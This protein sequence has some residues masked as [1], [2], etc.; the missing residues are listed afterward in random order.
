MILS[1][2]QARNCKLLRRVLIKQIIMNKNKIAMIIKLLI[3]ILGSAAVYY[4]YVKRKSIM[5]PN[6]PSKSDE[7]RETT[8]EQFESQWNYNGSLRE[9]LLEAAA[10]LWESYV[11]LEDAKKV[12]AC[13]KK[14]IYDNAI[15]YYGHEAEEVLSSDY[16]D[17]KKSRLLLH[18]VCNDLYN[19]STMYLKRDAENQWQFRLSDKYQIGHDT[20][21][22]YAGYDTNIAV[23]DI[24]ELD[25]VIEKLRSETGRYKREKELFVGNEGYK[26]YCDICHALIPPAM[27]FATLAELEPEPETAIV[28][29]RARTFCKA[30]EHA[31]KQFHILTDDE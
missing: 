23:E 13:M 8:K 12:E 31:N 9:Q 4:A 17:N 20:L 5:P 25:K 14:L 7:E 27:D 19:A 30:I 15:M 6:K 18:R 11:S 28:L 29:E 22:Y 26:R 2:V 24:K 21:L 10:K 1:R 16:A 3:G